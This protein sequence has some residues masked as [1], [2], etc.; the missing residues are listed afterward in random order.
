MKFLLNLCAILIISASSYGQEISYD[1]FRSVIP[2]LQNEDF[3]GAFDRTSQL[4]KSTQ[5]DSSDLHGIVIYMNIFSAAGMATLDLMTHSEFAKIVNSYVGQ[6]LVMSAHPCVDSASQGF[7]SLKFVTENGQ[8]MG[9]TI[10]ANKKGT[11]ILCF[12]Y[13]KYADQVNPKDFIGKN[14]RCGGTLKSVEVNPNNSKIWISRLH[15]ED[16]FAREMTPR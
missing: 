3:K 4:L 5:N 15:I 9:T 8:L 6:R 11:N 1:D 10:T 13:F 16:A 7:N 2:F 14:I 12:E